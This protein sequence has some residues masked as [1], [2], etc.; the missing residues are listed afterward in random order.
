MLQS[1]RDLPDNTTAECDVCV[2]GSGPAG[3]TIAREL[4]G[5]SARVFLLEAGGLD[6]DPD[7]QNLVE[8]D[9]VG[10][11]YHHHETRCRV[12][13]GSTA[14]WGGQCGPLDPHDF[15]RRSWIDHSGWPISQTDIDDYA[16][17]AS[18]MQ[19][20]PAT[21]YDPHFW[22]GEP[23]RLL[24]VGAAGMDHRIWQYNAPTDFGLT[25]RDDLAAAP[26]LRV[27][28]HANATEIVL[29]AYARTVQGVRVKTLEGKSGFVAARLVILACGGIENARM[30]LLSNRVARN[31][32]GNNYDLV[33]RFFADHP[34][35]IAGQVEFAPGLRKDWLSAYKQRKNHGTAYRSGFALTAE[36]QRELEVLNCGV[37]LLDWYVTDQWNCTQSRGYHAVKD[38]LRLAKQSTAWSHLKNDL[39]RCR[40]PDGLAPILADLATHPFGAAAGVLS[41]LRGNSIVAF[42]QSEQAPNPNSRITLSEQRDCL[43]MRKARIDWRLQPID[44]ITIR[45]TVERLSA[46]LTHLGLGR[47]R[48][49]EWLTHDDVTWLDVHGGGHHH[50]GTTRMS[51]TPSTGVV[52]RD[53]R[54]HGLENLY[55]AGSSVFPTVGF[56]NPTLTLTALS[57][58]LAD[59][60]KER[61]Q[62]E[63]EQPLAAV[64]AR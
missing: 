54:V 27:L 55:I 4:I 38:L 8:A 25:Y 30:L 52:D 9:V 34:H 22:D 31:G 45:A 35:Q 60:L 21:N 58:R 53:C 5:S 15:A 1:L 14:R 59:H 19:L 49:F 44:K 51:A 37:Q 50:I 28:L 17:R 33:G 48:P 18:A 43:G 32:I 56:M 40:M 24:D 64:S 3:I 46:E 41:R 12:L 36:A 42:T 10:F 16:E 61:L 6:I 47:I 29:D 23:R 39:L 11:A 26:N 20:L 2:I 57:L 13:G 63:P 62:Y 7:Q